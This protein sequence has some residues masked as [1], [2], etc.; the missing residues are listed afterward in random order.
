MF[1]S[2][3]EEIYLLWYEGTI[4]GVFVEVRNMSKRNKSIEEEEITSIIAHYP[5]I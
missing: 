5:W 3:E 4:D 1:I 2:A